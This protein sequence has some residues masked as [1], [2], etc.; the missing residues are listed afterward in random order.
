MLFFLSVLELPTFDNNEK[1]TNIVTK[2]KK[3]YSR[4]L[5]SSSCLNYFLLKILDI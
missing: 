2:L 1:L 5:L 4:V 3:I